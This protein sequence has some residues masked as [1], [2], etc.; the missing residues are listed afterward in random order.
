MKSDYPIANIYAAFK[1]L[2]PAKQSAFLEMLADHFSGYRLGR[3]G[4][5]DLAKAI[6]RAAQPNS[7][8]SLS[9]ITVRTS[10]PHVD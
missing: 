8:L 7:S 10:I 3:D 9:A 1:K 4:L 6:R 5:F 2:E